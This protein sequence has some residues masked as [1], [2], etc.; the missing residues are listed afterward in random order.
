MLG[1]AKIVNLPKQIFYPNLMVVPP[2]NI[3]YDIRDELGKIDYHYYVTACRN[4][5]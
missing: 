2:G 5:V 3:D 4:F 1:V